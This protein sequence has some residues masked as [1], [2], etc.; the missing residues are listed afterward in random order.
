MSEIHVSIIGRVNVGKSTLF[1]RLTRTRDALVENTAGVTRDRKEGRF[2]LSDRA[3]LLVDTGGIDSECAKES[4]PADEAQKQSLAAVVD[5]DMLLF[6][7]DGRAGVMP[8]DH[9]IAQKIRRSGK[10]VILVANKMESEHKASDFHDFYK[11]GMGDPVAISAEHNINISG[12]LDALANL[13]KIRFQGTVS[14]RIA[15]KE[16]TRIAVVGRPNVGKSSFLNAVIGKN[17]HIV[18]DVPGTTRDSVDSVLRYH[19][20]QYRLI[21]TA[22][23]KRIGR[24]TEKLDKLAAIMARR[25]IERCHVALLLIDAVEGVTSQDLKIA[26]YIVDEGRG[27][28]IIANK[29]D[30][31]TRTTERYKDLRQKIRDSFV[32]MPWA[33]FMVMS[34]LEKH[35]VEKVFTVIENVM[36]SSQS[37]VSTGQ[38]NRVIQEAQKIHPPPRKDTRRPVKI[39]Y[40]AQVALRPPTFLMFTNTRSEIHFSYRRFLANRIRESFGYEGWPIRLVFRHRRDERGRRWD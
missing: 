19:G 11:L 27:C 36:D 8:D 9:I 7:V 17:R 13:L 14:V 35:N 16:E 32:A 18:T 33:P 22:G 31:T 4:K 15:S 40:S 6:V 23:L 29:W 30:L 25:S 24:T 10:P 38:L 2:F 39:Y 12:L 20:K 28:I 21:D 3:I 34:A 26:S 37:Q 5:S 1:N